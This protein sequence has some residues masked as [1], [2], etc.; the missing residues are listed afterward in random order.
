MK[1]F[2]IILLSMVIFGC[3]KAGETGDSIKGT[4]D[5]SGKAQKITV[6]VYETRGDMQR[7]LQDQIG[8]PRDTSR[9]GWSIWSNIEE[10]GC[11]IHVVKI[12]NLTDNGR[13]STWGHELAHCMYGTYHPEG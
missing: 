5:R 9:D 10:N 1:Y 6:M 2:I 8:G 11:T 7:A 4:F 3:D 13:R 12:R